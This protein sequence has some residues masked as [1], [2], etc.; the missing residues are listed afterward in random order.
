[1]EATGAFPLPPAQDW[2]MELPPHRPV[3]V[4]I[5]KGLARIISD[6]IDSGEAN[7]PDLLRMAFQCASTFR[8]TDHRGGCNGARILNAPQRNFD[9]NKE[10]VPT[11]KKVLDALHYQF[12]DVSYADLIVLAG[13]VAA[14]RMTKAPFLFCPGRRDV[15]DGPES[16]ATLRDRVNRLPPAI[17]DKQ[18]ILSAKASTLTFDYVRNAARIM[19]VTDRQLSALFGGVGLGI[20]TR[21]VVD[22][23]HLKHLGTLMS[24]YHP[25]DTNIFDMTFRYDPQLSSVAQAHAAD[26]ELFINDFVDA[27]TS[28]MNA[29]RFEISCDDY[30]NVVMIDAGTVKSDIVI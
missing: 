21:S 26:N 24:G 18:L 12:D 11:V 30:E 23:S 19:G 14:A 6:K 16:Y 8:S 15:Y 4:N 17:H 25:E 29:D 3:S 13:T 1:M 9:F 10:L 22:N 5:T 20:A 2:Q 28:L 27:W 7:A